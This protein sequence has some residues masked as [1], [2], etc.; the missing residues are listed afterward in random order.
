MCSLGEPLLARCTPF[1]DTYLFGNLLSCY[2]EDPRTK[3]MCNT[4]PPWGTS[5]NQLII[6]LKYTEEDNERSTVESTLCY[7]T[8]Y[9]NETSRLYDNRVTFWKGGYCL[10][11]NAENP[12]GLIHTKLWCRAAA[13]WSVVETFYSMLRAH[14]KHFYSMLAMVCIPW[15]TQGM[16][17]CLMHLCIW[18]LV[19]VLLSIAETWTKTG[20]LFHR[21]NLISH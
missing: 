11:L 14:K 19:V 18:V 20:E 9:I 1:W 4:P 16:G 8:Y 12:V 7:Y 10:L 2:L 3:N 5:K 6:T 13:L 15:N 17:L 21:Y